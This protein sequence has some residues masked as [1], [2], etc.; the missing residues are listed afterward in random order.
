MLGG[1]I[2]PLLSNI[3]LHFLEAVWQP[4][5]ATVGK[6]VRYADDFVVLCRSREDVE[7]AER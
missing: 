6:L 4:Q 1:E 7:E 5:C 2:S 3:D